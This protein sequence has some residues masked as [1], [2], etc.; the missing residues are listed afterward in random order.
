MPDTYKTIQAD[1][2]DIISFKA[3]GNEKM[4][5]V[6]LAANPALQDTVLFEAGV[7]II[8]PELEDTDT[9]QSTVPPW[10]QS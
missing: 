1:M 2:W 4:M 8:V 9:A 6:L 10:L 5:H 7:Q 3:Y